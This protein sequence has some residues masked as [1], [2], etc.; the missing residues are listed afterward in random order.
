M[1]NYISKFLTIISQNGCECETFMNMR[2]KNKQ[3]AIW[4]EA[5]EG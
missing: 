5:K 1:S 3:T 4:S 2:G